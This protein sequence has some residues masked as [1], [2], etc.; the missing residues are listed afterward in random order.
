MSRIDKVVLSAPVAA[1]YEEDHRM[2][3]FAFRQAHVNKLI[4]VLAI[5]ETQVGYRRLFA[6]DVFALHREIIKQA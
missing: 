1:V 2:W 3:P 5:R 6:E 4:W